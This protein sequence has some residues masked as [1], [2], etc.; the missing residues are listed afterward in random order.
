MGGLESGSAYPSFEHILYLTSVS[1][2]GQNM[3]HLWISQNVAGFR[4]STAEE[5]FLRD[6]MRTLS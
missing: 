1:V 2:P 5:A 6:I 3:P 4:K